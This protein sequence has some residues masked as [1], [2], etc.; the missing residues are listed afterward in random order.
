MTSRGTSLLVALGLVACATEPPA[1][2]PAPSRKAIAAPSAEAPVDASDVE[3]ASDSGAPDGA[4]GTEEPR[5]SLPPPSAPPGFAPPHERTA[6]Q[7]DGEWTPSAP[8]QD[9]PLLY[10]TSVHPSP[11]KGHVKVTLVAFDLTRVA[12]HLVAGTR[13]PVAKAVPGEARPGVVPAADRGALLAVTNGGWRSE[14]GHFAMR[15]GPHRFEVPKPGACTI[16]LGPAG[17]QIAPWEEIAPKDSELWAWR[18]TPACLVLRGALHPALVRETMTRRWG[19]AVDGGVEIPRTAL[20]LHGSGRYALFALGEST[21]AKALADALIAAGT[22]SAAELD[23]N[24]SYTRFFLYDRIA[25]SQSVRIVR[26]IA[27]K[28]E[29]PPSSYVSKSS[30]RDFFYFVRKAP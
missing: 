29:H 13:E 28:G 17:L 21:T 16:A 23:I 11:Q 27:T 12:V 26:S 4:S 9:T 22:T 8:Q 14:H 24:W 20:G 6:A 7:G 30:E 15:V 25:E 1:V 19:A 10:E 3:G 5:V 18:Q 2:G